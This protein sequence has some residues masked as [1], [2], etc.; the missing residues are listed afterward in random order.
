MA[1]DSATRYDRVTGAWKI[2]M[3]DNLHFGYFEGGDLD[4]KR[5]TERMTERMLELGEIDKDSRI[6]D[7]GCGIGEPAFYIYERCG[8]CIDGISTSRRGIEL[9]QNAA[10]EKGCQEVRFRVADGMDNGFPDAS[11]DLVWIMEALH[12]FRTR[13]SFFASAIGCSKKTGGWLCATWSSCP[14]F[15]CSR[16]YGASRPTSRICFSRPTFGDRRRF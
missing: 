12:P 9:A 10:R 15:L 1:V 6:L 5:A 8:C 16:D 4:L 3:G 2:F 13:G 11:F 14:L 7:V